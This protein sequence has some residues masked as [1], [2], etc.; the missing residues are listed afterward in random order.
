MTDGINIL[1]TG[2]TRSG[3]SY[4]IKHSLQGER[5]FV[6]LT[7]RDEY[8]WPGV[9]FDGLAG[10]HD[11]MVAWWMHCVEQGV[12][13]R[14]VYRPAD[15]FDWK[16]F[17]AVC[18]LIYACG[19]VTFVAEEIKTYLRSS[20]LQAKGTEG[21][22]NLLQAGGS[23]GIVAWWV[24]QSPRNIPVEV[25]GQSRRMY[26]FHNAEPGDVSYLEERIGRA[27]VERMAA[28]GLYEFVDWLEDGTF[29]VRKV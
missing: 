23:R 15:I 1:V 4:L 27:A 8:D 9:V 22:K 19:N 7:K 13:F 20:T 28:L 25:R 17:D 6:Y 5:L 10:E 3:K 24:T 21:V 26:L 14:I 18:R 2:Q 12:P 11:A 16:E 29:A